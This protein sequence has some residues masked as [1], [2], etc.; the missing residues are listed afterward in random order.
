MT[1]YVVR[2]LLSFICIIRDSNP[3]GKSYLS[4]DSFINTII[5]WFKKFA[6][7][8]ETVS[9]CSIKAYSSICIQ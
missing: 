6:P 8:I 3:V 4:P 7:L 9:L 5:S 1:L 2:Y